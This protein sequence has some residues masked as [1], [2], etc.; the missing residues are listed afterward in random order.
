M[1]DVMVSGTHGTNLKSVAKT[2]SRFSRP[3][4]YRPKRDSHHCNRCGGNPH[5]DMT[6]CPAK[7]KK[8]Q[9]CGMFGHFGKVCRKSRATGTTSK[10]AIRHVVLVAG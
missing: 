9:K 2:A 6:K 10:S 5:S 1:A 4:V 3:V 7:G 8:C